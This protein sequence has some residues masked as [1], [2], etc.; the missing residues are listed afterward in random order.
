MGYA[1]EA[2]RLV[3]D[4]SSFSE[5]FVK[6]FSVEVADTE[7]LRRDAFRLRYRVYCEER[8]FERSEYF[9][10]Q[11]ESDKFDDASVHAVV[12]HR[13]TGIVV[14]AVRLILRQPANPQ[15]LL[16]LERA[17]GGLLDRDQLRKFDSCMHSVAEV[18]RFAVSKSAVVE[19][20]ER[21]EAGSSAKF[22]DDGVQDLLGGNPFR[23]IALGLISALFQ[24]S[25]ACGID[26]WYAL[27]EPALARHLSR[28]GLHFTRVGP[29]VN[30]RGK[31][32]P[33]LASLWHL[34]QDILDQNPELHELIE[35]NGEPVMQRTRRAVRLDWS[36]KIFTSNPSFPAAVLQLR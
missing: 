19:V 11:L 8:K 13:A 3:P 31:R 14:G 1:V 12:R 32:Q 18:S 20:T 29:L 6:M 27:M 4:S 36:Q 7:Q 33:M 9:P 10:D 21:S 25:A 2:T 34:R 22:S 30:H 23:S 24:M 15:N 28:L 26:H 35:F 17:C 5:F 16:P